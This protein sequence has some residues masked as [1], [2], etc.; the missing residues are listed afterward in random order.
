MCAFDERVLVL[1]SGGPAH[2]FP[3]L[4]GLTP[5]F[6]GLIQP[7]TLVFH[8]PDHWWA[9]DQTQFSACRQCSGDFCHLEIFNCPCHTP[10][11]NGHSKWKQNFVC[12]I[13][14]WCDDSIGIIIQI[15]VVLKRGLFIWKGKIVD[16]FVHWPVARKQEKWDNVC[17]PHCAIQF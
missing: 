10:V 8:L 15:K 1:S 6:F 5:W 7:V 16:A 9:I 3:V 11:S 2:H 13:K 4:S 14:N 17:N 12:S